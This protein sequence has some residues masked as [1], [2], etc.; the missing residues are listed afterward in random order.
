MDKL[1]NINRVGGYPLVAEGLQILQDHEK[2]ITANLDA[3]DI[4]Y[5]TCVILQYQS[6]GL[7]GVLI[8]ALVYVVKSISIASS[9]SGVIVRLQGDGTTRL[10]HLLSGATQKSIAIT[11]TPHTVTDGI[12]NYQ[13]AY[14]T[15]MAELVPVS[16][17]NL[18]YRFAK[19]S[20][21]F[22]QN[23][24]SNATIRNAPGASFQLAWSSNVQSKILVEKKKIIFDLHLD[25]DVIDLANNS[26]FYAID[27]SSLIPIPTGVHTLTCNLIGY[28]EPL[29][30]WNI[31]TQL[32]LPCAIY[33][34]A[35]FFQIPN[36][37]LSSVQNL[38]IIHITG[39]VL[40]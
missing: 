10:S 6:H 5:R 25:R 32:N 1:N 16:T 19:L 24:I 14:I 31:Q 15:Q 28:V 3:L 36:G 22:S 29:V 8:E 9:T 37:S 38:D 30:D 11:S 33:N 12:N 26:S 18:A 39:T 40:I 21:V 4:P 17:Q 20:D 7:T 34:S 13:D 23:R 27:L 2:T 35:I